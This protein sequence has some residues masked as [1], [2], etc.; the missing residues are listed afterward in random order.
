MVISAEYDVVCQRY[1][2]SCI[3]C[4]NALVYDLI[5][6]P[7]K[8]EHNKFWGRE[9]RF[10]AVITVNNRGLIRKFFIGYISREMVRMKMKCLIYRHAPSKEG[11]QFR[12]GFLRI[13]DVVHHAF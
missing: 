1:S 11:L 10:G 3:S 8:L 2:F 7:I 12:Y 13:V 5:T 9:R 6:R 4:T